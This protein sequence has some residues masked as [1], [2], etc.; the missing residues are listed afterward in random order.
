MQ[1]TNR[2]RDPLIFRAYTAIII[3]CF[4][5]T[6]VCIPQFLTAQ[7]ASPYSQRGEVILNANEFDYNLRKNILVINS[8]HQGHPWTDGI[9]RG[10]LNTFHKRNAHVEVHIENLDSKRIID[11]ELWDTILKQKL[12]SYPPE[13]VDLIIVSDDNALNALKDIGHEYHDLPIVFCGISHAPERFFGQCSCIIGIKEYLPHKENLE[14]G[15]RLF[16]DTENIVVI[17]DNSETGISHR[18]AAEKAIA[19]LALEDVRI[20]WLDGTKG[21]TTPEMVRQLKILPEHTLVLFSIWQIDGE[22]NYWD[23][24]KYYRLYAEACNAPVFLVTDV[25]LRNGFLGG[26][27]SVSEKQGELAS[28]LGLKILYQGYRPDRLLYDD[29]NQWY[30]NWKELMRWKIPRHS[31]PSGAIIFNRPMAVYREYR[32]FFWFTLG[33]IIALFVMLWLAI[34]YHF[35]YRRNENLRTLFAH[36]TKRLAER[37]NILFNQASYAI[38]IFEMESGR[39]REINEKASELFKMPRDIFLSYCMRDYF[40]NYD[41]LKDQIDTMLAAPFERQLWRYGGAPFY[42]QV[43]L[44]T[45]KEEDNIFIHALVSDVSNRKEQEKEIAEGRDRLN[46]ALLFSKNAYVEW[47]IVNKKLKKDDTFWHALDIDPAMLT[48]DSEDSEY[49]LGH[50]HPEDIK[51]LNKAINGA[52]RGRTDTFHVE[53]RMCFFGREIWVEIRAAV[54]DRDEKRRACRISGFMMNIDH[55]KK[56]EE[57][58]IHAKERA[59][60]SDRLKSAFISNISHEIR[61]PLN[62]IVGFSNL[63]GRENLSIEDKRKYLAFINE[64]NDMLLKLINDI[65]EISKIETDSIPVK[66]EPCSVKDLCRDIVSQESIDLPPTL[67]LRLAEVQDLNV[68]LDK[69]KLIQVLKSLLSN[70][71]KFTP[72]GI[73]TLGY[74]IHSNTI[75]FFV[76]DNGIGIP[77]DMLEAVFERFVQVDPFSKGTGLGLAISK[78]IIDKIGGEI[79]IESVEGKGTVVHFTFTYKKAEVSVRDIEPAVGSE[80]VREEKEKPRKI[81]LIAEHD[82]SNFVLLNV[83]LSNTYRVIRTNTFDETRDHIKLY[84]PD[85]VLME[86]D[87]PG[88]SPKTAPAKIKAIREHIPL[89][90]IRSIVG[91]GKEAYPVQEGFDDYLNKPINIKHLIEIIEKHLN[92]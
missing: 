11:P 44:H 62:G 1:Y 30:F 46:N 3:Y 21:L 63:L 71:K 58:L 80:T 68:R 78:A 55:R 56:Q 70:A 83:L 84:K 92:L 22:G 47:D 20:I 39:V 14:L 6:A 82:E 24:E 29:E 5:L 90:G 60:E 34:I 7:T 8:Y 36:E 69:I 41:E 65:L 59:E 27:I 57:E 61:T 67:Q 49:F 53:F 48:T 4:C 79:W 87:L 17:T 85:I 12:N 40:S 13:Y 91:S 15:I 2:K 19:L 43:L 77:E 50:V 32:L 52:I 66:L 64:N 89:I 10:I 86:T 42:A 51:E 81:V 54:S 25:G 73:I 31:L 88:I 37:Y 9:T 28:E 16:P 18:T 74:T 75:E 45:L 26:Y 33:L 35:R 38:V 76:E 72:K 23:P